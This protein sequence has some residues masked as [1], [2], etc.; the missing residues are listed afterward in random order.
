M[1]TRT[2]H[3]RGD[4]ERLRDEL[5]QAASALLLAARPSAA[6]SLRAIA[7]ECGVA[8]SAVYRHFP[9]QEALLRAVVEVHFDHLRSALDAVEEADAEPGARVRAMARTYVGWALEH[10]GAYQLLFERPDPEGPPGTGPGLDLLDRLARALPGEHSAGRALRLWSAVHGVA[11]LRI[12]KPR[13]PW[14]TTP[15]GDVDAVVAALVR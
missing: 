13:A 4:G 3:Q 14:V 12:H 1:R 2:P 8:P 15:D 7:R 10:P 6:P 11:S 9:S 5:I